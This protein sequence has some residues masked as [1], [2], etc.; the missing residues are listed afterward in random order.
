MLFAVYLLA[1]FYQQRHLVSGQIPEFRAVTLKGKLIDSKVWG[2][3]PVLLNFWATWCPVCKLEQGMI[4]ELAKD[5]RVITIAMN[6]GGKDAIELYLEEHDLDFP[7]I[8]DVDGELARRFGVTGVP[9]GFVIDRNGSIRFKEIGLTSSWG[10]RARL[11]LAQ[12]L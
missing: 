12:L 7:V 9:T 11:Q 2:D 8:V 10:W 6:S 3:K 1:Q 4:N 5:Y